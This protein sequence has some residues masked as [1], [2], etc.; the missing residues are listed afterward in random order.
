MTFIFQQNFRNQLLAK[1]MLLWHLHTFSDFFPCTSLYKH[2][3]VLREFT[4]FTDD[5]VMWCL[6][7]TVSAA[8]YCMMWGDVCRWIK[9]TITEERLTLKI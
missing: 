9:G 2:Q 1:N 7:S 3:E 4:T 8:Y 6:L 5:D